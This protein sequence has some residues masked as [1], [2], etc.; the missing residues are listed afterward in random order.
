MRSHASEETV[1]SNQS[2]SNLALQQALIRVI[3][4]HTSIRQFVT[5][6]AD[7]TARQY[8]IFCESAIVYSSITED[9]DKIAF[10][11]SRLL[12]GSRA[13]NLMQSS[14][15]AA[16]DIGVNYEIF[17]ENFI[18]I[19]LG[20]VNLGSLDKWPT[21]YIPSKRIPQQS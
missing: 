18:K 10:I 6:E 11:R 21:R 3:H 7:Y 20:V 15:F 12:P 8:L 1:A 19:F 17:K 9:H 2:L 5:F 16:G 13:L 14:A 4:T